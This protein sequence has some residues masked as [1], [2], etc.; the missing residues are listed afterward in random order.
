VVASSIVLCRKPGGRS[1]PEAL[2]AHHW[3]GSDRAR[4]VVQ[5]CRA[6]LPR[7]LDVAGCESVGRQFYVRFIEVFGDRVDRACRWHHRA[8]AEMSTTSTAPRQAEPARSEVPSRFAALVGV[9]AVGAAVDSGQLVASL[10]SPASSPVLTAGPV[11]CS[12]PGRRTRLA[13]GRDRE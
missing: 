13:V 2:S 5:H 9:L 4:C 1:D 6:A 12:A 10:V 7:G 11:A 8:D 3:L